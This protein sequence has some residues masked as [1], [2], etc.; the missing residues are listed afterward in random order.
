MQSLLLSLR[1]SFS[2]VRPLD[3]HSVLRLSLRK[4]RRALAASEARM[5]SISL[6]VAAAAA[7][8]FDIGV[9]EIAS[10]E[11]ANYTYT[12]NEVGGWVTIFGRAVGTLKNGLK[13]Y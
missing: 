4:L 2:R 11:S 1:S 7:A 9:K 10:H 8:W 12:R 5:A 13:Y 3:F 6:Y